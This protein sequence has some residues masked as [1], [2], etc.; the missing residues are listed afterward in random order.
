MPMHDWTR[1]SAGVY[2]D[3]HCRWLGEVTSRLNEGLLPEDH[4]AQVEQML[5]GATADL[6]TLKESKPTPTEPG[7]MGGVALAAAPPRVR[8]TDVLEAEMYASRARRVVVRHSSD[9]RI[10]A[11]LE[12]VSPGNKSAAKHPLRTFVRKS[13]SLLRRGA[14]LVVIDPFPPTPRDPQGMHGLIWGELGGSYQPPPDKPLTMASYTATLPRHAFVEPLAVGD[15]LTE[16]PLF[17]D[18]EHYIPLPLEETYMRI[19]GTVARRFREALEG[20]PPTT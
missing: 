11:V 10:V 8:I 20:T 2:H 3:F 15:P 13:L 14:H 17:L 19:H 9:D 16:M 5:G 7:G 6:L 12:L 1:V 4:Y 18:A